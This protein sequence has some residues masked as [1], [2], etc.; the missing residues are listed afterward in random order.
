MDRKNVE[1]IVSR[2]LN[3]IE[4]AIPAKVTDVA[5]DGTLSVVALIR[6][7][8]VDGIVDTDNLAIGGVRPFV[9]GNSS[10]SVE[11]GIGKG[12]QVLLVSLS[13][14]A[15]EWLATSSD[16]PV[17]PRSS[18]GNMLNDIVAIPMFRS[19]R[20]NGQASKITLGEDGTVEVTSKYGQTLKFE[21]DGSIAFNPKTGGKVKIAG[22]LEVGGN[23]E[24][25]SGVVKGMDF[26]TSALSFLT[27]VHECAA[28]ASPSGPAMSPPTAS[29]P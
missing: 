26:Q 14:H 6:K 11:I 2:R 23:V 15:R 12:A 10:A 5:E 18:N 25:T 16:D 21:E 28:P 8:T 13:R 4:T 22:D 29:T 17:T 19:D 24:S 27:H 20:K 9:I 1:E 3:G 7:V